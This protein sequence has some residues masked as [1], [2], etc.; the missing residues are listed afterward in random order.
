MEKQK[1]LICFATIQGYMCSTRS[2]ILQQSA[3]ASR[4]RFS[5]CVRL[6]SRWRCSKSWIGRRLTTDC[7]ASSLCD[8]P[9]RVRRR[10][11]LQTA[12]IYS[13]VSREITWLAVRSRVALQI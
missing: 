11:I 10:F 8:S 12:R 2:S 1:L 6:M 9:A 5:A 13:G 3:R 4:S 7:L